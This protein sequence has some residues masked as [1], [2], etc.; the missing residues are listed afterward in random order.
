MKIVDRLY[1]S[2]FKYV[3]MVIMI[4]LGGVICGISFNAFIMPH[5]LL[6]GGISGIALILNYLFGISPG[7]LIFLFNIPIFAIGIKFID[8]EFILLSLVG[9][10]TFSLFIDVFG[11]LKHMVY[12]DDV[13]LSCIFGGILNGVGM[14]IVFRNR[15]SQG[16]IDIVA[17]IVKKYFSLNLGSTSLI[18]NF[19]IVSFA[20]FIFNNLMLAMYTLISMYVGSAVLDKVIDGFDIRKSVMIISNSEKAVGDEIIKRLHRGV[21][22]LDGEGAYTSSKKKVVYCIVTLNQLA[23]LKQ[24]V[25][26]IDPNAFMTVSDTT[27]VLGQGFSKRGV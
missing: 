16:G 19:I 10:V 27:E 20:A 21:T 5:K 6:S 11:F 1:D 2:K 12:V 25:R 9:M 17:V 4:M 7:L 26:E 3:F 8:K 14:G 13:M 22:Y 23:K 24:I 15:A 18:I